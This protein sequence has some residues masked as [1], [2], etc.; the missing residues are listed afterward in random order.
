MK[1]SGWTIVIIGLCLGLSALSFA[2]FQVYMPV[3]EAAK[4]NT[5]YKE[6]LQTEADKLPKA[7]ARVREAIKKVKEAAVDWNRYVANR[8]PPETLAAGGVNVFENPYQLVVDTPRYRDSAQRAFNLQIHRGGVRVV[9]APEIPHPSDSEKDILVGYYNYP[10]FGFPVVLWELGN[11]TVQ[12]TYAQIMQNVRSWATMPRYLAVTDGLRI[13]GT[14][15]NLTASYNVTIVGFIRA[16]QMFPAPAGFQFGEA[17]NNGGTPGAGGPGGGG[18]GGPGPG[19]L[20]PKAPGG[21][22]GF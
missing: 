10:A 12:G 11:V 15:P 4:Y 22:Q 16:N 2:L 7:E 19:S 1:L 5:A 21:P 13:D 8:T 6:A 14:S 18:R 3:E 20:T 17:S 9:S